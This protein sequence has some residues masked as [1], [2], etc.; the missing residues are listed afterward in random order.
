MAVPRIMADFSSQRFIR[1]VLRLALPCGSTSF[2]VSLLFSVYVIPKRLEK[3]V[4]KVLCF[5]EYR[6]NLSR[7]E[8]IK[9]IGNCPLMSMGLLVIV[10]ICIIGFIQFFFI[11]LND[12]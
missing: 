8:D 1:C 2:D 11:Y 4:H 9:I 7:K 12:A 6:G 5:V 3:R 10:S